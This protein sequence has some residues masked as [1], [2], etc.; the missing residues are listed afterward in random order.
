MTMI[1][2]LSPDLHG[3]ENRKK[4]IKVRILAAYVFRHRTNQEEKIDSLFK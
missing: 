1:I 2:H 3:F 4:K